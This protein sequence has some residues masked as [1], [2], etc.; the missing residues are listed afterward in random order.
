MSKLTFENKGAALPFDQPSE[1]YY[2]RAIKYLDKYEYE[3]AVANIRKAIDKNSSNVDYILELAGILSDIE[4]FDDS[5]ELLFMLLQESDEPIAECY[6]GI[7]CNFFWLND[8]KKASSCLLKYLKL[9][10]DGTFVEDASIILENIENEVYVDNP[11]ATWRSFLYEGNSKKAIDELSKLSDDSLIDYV[12]IR[13]NLTVAYLL[14][15][16]LEEAEDCCNKVLSIEPDNVQGICNMALIK[17][18]LGNKEKAKE[19]VEQVMEQEEVHTNKEHDVNNLLKISVA[20]C[21]L[22]MHEEAINIFSLILEEHPYDSHALHFNAIALFNTGLYEEALQNL[23]TISIFCP[24]NS[25]NN[26]YIQLVKDTIAGTSD[27]D[28]LP[29]EN[30][31]STKCIYKR[32][33]R[34]NDILESNLIDNPWENGEFRELVL[35]AFNIKDDKLKSSMI[36]LIAKY[37]GDEASKILFSKL[38]SRYVSDEVKHKILI[39]LKEIDAKEPYV[40]ILDGSIVEINVNTFEVNNDKHINYQKEIIELLLTKCLIQYD[41]DF[42]HHIIGVWNKI[43]SNEDLFDSNE[44]C[45]LWAAVLEYEYVLTK[46]IPTNPNVIASKYDIDTDT[47]VKI[48]DKIIN[49][50]RKNDGNISN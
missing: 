36:T 21:E 45:N 34:I 13:N 27:T 20:L 30:Q 15:S 19:Y 4:H 12:F 2:R 29:Y 38:C 47:M 23:I 11:I 42:I 26:W 18:R 41:Q 39:K 32:I 35:W 9:S 6:Y 1:F 14:D 50:Q 17:S 37:A 7:G 22:D 46:D 40:A 33:N 16:Q 24:D 44:S 3:K 31:V 10:P 8:H 48:A 25:I 5:N 49:E 43:I 28:Y